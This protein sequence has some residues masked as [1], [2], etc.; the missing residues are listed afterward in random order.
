[1][2]GCSNLSFTLI[3]SDTW[4]VWMLADSLQINLVGTILSQQDPS[5]S[6]R[7]RFSMS[8]APF[9][10]FF[11]QSGQLWRAMLLLELDEAMLQLNPNLTFPFT[12]STSLSL[13]GNVLQCHPRKLPNVILHLRYISHLL[14]YL[15]LQIFWQ[16]DFI[17]HGS[18]SWVFFH[19]ISLYSSR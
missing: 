6:S 18:F 2:Y 13:T 15:Y 1:M 3:P 4:G 5:L 11:F 12:H 8:L 19:Y 16:C 7:C 9:F 10:F 17:P 14:L